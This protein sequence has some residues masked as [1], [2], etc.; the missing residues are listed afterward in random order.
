MF[1]P[2]MTGIGLSASSGL[3]AFLPLLIIGLIDRI[4]DGE[5][6]SDPYEFLSSMPGIVVLLALVTIELLVDKSPFYRM[7]DVIQ[8]VLRPAS[9]ALAFMAGTS[10]TDLNTVVAL[11]AGLVIAG[12]V[13]VAKGGFRLRLDPRIRKTIIPM[14]SLI[15][16]IYVATLAPIA[17]LVPEAVPVVIL[18][19]IGAII[20]TLRRKPLPDLPARSPAAPVDPTL[21]KPESA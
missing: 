19:L 4:R 12:I 18:P 5:V 20:W 6:L 15:E 13:H 9:G 10:E 7:N 1:L 2:L 8:G 16:D 14:I 17:L 21:E 3:N 11:I